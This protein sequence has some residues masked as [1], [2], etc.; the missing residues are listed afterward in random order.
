VDNLKLSVGCNWDRKLIENLSGLPVY[1]L[2]GKVDKDIVGGGRPSYLLPEI[3]EEEIKKYIDEVHKNGMEFTYLLNSFCM[4]N[5]EFVAES[6]NK[7]IEYIERIVDMGVDCITVTIPY[8]LQIIKHRFPKLKVGVS[9]F[10]YINSVRRAQL[11]E[12]LGADVIA[13]PEFVNRDFKLLSAIR[14]SVKCEIQLLANVTCIYGCPFQLYHGTI[15]SH[16][17]QDDKYTQGFYIDYCILNCMKRKMSNRDE[18]IKSRWIRPEDLH[19]YEEIGIDYFKI[20]ERFNTTE[21]ITNTVKAYAQ[22]AYD[23][24]LID[25]LDVKTDPKR[26]V[27]IN[28]S[29]FNKPEFANVK[30]LMDFEDALF[31]KEQYLD[32]KSLD[33]F[34]EHFKYNDCNKTSCEDCGYCTSIANKAYKVDEDKAQIALSKVNKKL[35]NLITSEFF[36][37]KPSKGDNN[38]QWEPSCKSLF[39]Q[40]ISSVEAEVRDIAK[41]VVGRQAEDNARERNSLLVEEQDMV[42]AFLSET[43]QNEQENMRKKLIE[44]GIKFENNI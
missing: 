26:Q 1:N 11:F 12:S 15:S 31:L 6:H 3:N 20:V 17:S 38:M 21:V 13:L 19:I 37:I 28:V 16:A 36:N 43:P 5:K 14:K 39:E 42:N 8:L 23:G 7:I 9:I 10:A 33:G 4:G 44:L 22:R 30:N 40:L 29:Y 32:N 34:I 35:D 41:K 25:I 18:L 2:Y 24:N 27:P